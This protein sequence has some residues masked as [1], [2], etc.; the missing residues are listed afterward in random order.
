MKAI[1]QPAPRGSLSFT[2]LVLAALWL[3]GLL[4]VGYMPAASGVAGGGWPGL[5]L[6][7]ASL[8]QPERD[9]PA[10]IL[11]GGDVCVF[12]GLA[13]LPALAGP[14]LR[15]QAGWAVGATTLT[16]RTADPLILILG[17]PP[18]RA[19]PVA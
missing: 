10:T 16:A 15:L 2:I 1:S 3:R 14:A 19:P 9:K 11:H 12:A 4:P 17:V 6:C 8:G 5:A 18:A 13:A 7:R